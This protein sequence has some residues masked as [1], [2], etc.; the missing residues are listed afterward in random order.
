M[1]RHACLGLAALAAVS[2]PAAAETY[3]G[4]LTGVITSGSGGHDDALGYYNND[5]SFTVDLAGAPI[6]INFTADIQYNF[7]DPVGDF[8]ARYVTNTIDVRIPAASPVSMDDIGSTQ[9]NGYTVWQ[10]A[11]A[12]YTGGAKSGKLDADGSYDNDPDFW[13]T[14][15]FSFAGASPHSGPL[16][17]SGTAYASF[18]DGISVTDQY[19]V[20]FDLTSG[21]VSAGTPEPSAWSL[22]IVGF[23]AIGGIMRRRTTGLRAAA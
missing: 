2:A 13:Q 20:T 14:L 7:T 3:T 10:P 8:Y 16:T 1:I 11:S 22:M 12:D 21:F 6:T 9:A 19:K 4:T 23:G 5:P 17:G 15:D 18:Y